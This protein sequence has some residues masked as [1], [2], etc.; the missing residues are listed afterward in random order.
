MQKLSEKD[1]KAGSVTMLQDVRIDK[2]T[3]RQ[4]QQ[5]NR[6]Y[7]EELNEKF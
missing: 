6:G 5:R 1:F 3:E 2:Q 7:K 4:C